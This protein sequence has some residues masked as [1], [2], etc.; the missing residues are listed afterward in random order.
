MSGYWLEPKNY[1]VF[2]DPSVDMVDVHRIS[3]IR[4]DHDY[5]H[6]DLSN[7]VLL[8]GIERPNPISFSC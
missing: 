5:D 2:E 6:N 7:N 3:F 8:E 4:Y 1:L